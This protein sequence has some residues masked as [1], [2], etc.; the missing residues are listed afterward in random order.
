MK[1][2]IVLF[3]IFLLM[4][5]TGYCTLMN[6]EINVFNLKENNMY[7]L[8]VDSSVKNINISDRNVVNLTPVT[9]ISN[10]KK[11]IFIEANKSGVCDVV[12]TTDSDAYQIRF[13]S[14]PVFQDNISELVQIDVPFGINAE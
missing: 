5:Q 4:Q 6:Q 12:L 7:I 11:Q 1:K 9:S 2:I 10:D 14:G 3:T 13:V 8:N